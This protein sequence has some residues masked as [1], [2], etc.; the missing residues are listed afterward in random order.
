MIMHTPALEER[1]RRS[2]DVLFHEVRW[3]ADEAEYDLGDGTR[4]CRLAGSD[5]ARVY[6]SL[7]VINGVDDGEPFSYEV[8]AHFEGPASDTWRLPYRDPRSAIALRS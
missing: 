5:V 7:C 3:N 2:L 1:S 8:Y 6:E 4:L